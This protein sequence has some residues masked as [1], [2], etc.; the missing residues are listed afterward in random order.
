[1]EEPWAVPDVSLLAE[2]RGGEVAV[3]HLTLTFLDSGLALEKAG[4]G[5][6]RTAPGPRW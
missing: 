1:M 2:G 5:P 4:R 3:P 6:S